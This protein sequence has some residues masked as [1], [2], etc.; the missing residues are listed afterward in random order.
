MSPV[1]T[2]R[3]NTAEVTTLPP[4]PPQKK[5]PKTPTQNPNPLA[6]PMDVPMC[7]T[8]YLLM[9]REAG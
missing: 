1:N 5:K 3:H 6:D 9:A 7:F 2:T 8:V 4:L